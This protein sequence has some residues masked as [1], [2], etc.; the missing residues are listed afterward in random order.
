MVGLQSQL[1]PRLLWVP[2][3]S[4]SPVHLPQ[5]GYSL[6]ASQ[7]LAGWLGPAPG[8][9]AGLG[10]AGPGQAGPGRAGSTSIVSSCLQ[11]FLFYHSSLF[12]LTQSGWFFVVVLDF[13][14]KAESLFFFFKLPIPLR[15]VSFH[16]PHPCLCFWP[17]SSLPL[18]CLSSASPLPPQPLP[19]HCSQG[20]LQGQGDFR[21][22]SGGQPRLDPWNLIR[23]PSP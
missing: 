15:G 5:Q 2:P 4:P 1:L 13:H 12:V 19:T 7:A 8:G 11:N 14:V 17:S 3:G 22:W 18:L 23:R 20:S 6:R 16:H 9:W 10:W 21:R